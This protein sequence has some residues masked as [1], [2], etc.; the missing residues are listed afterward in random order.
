[1]L[2]VALLAASLY[3][4]D[5][6]ESEEMTETV[7]P[8]YDVALH[9]D[10]EENIIFSRYDVDV[11]LDDEKLGTIPHGDVADYSLEADEGEHRI[12]FASV[13]DSTTTGSVVIDVAEDCSL[14]YEIQCKHS[15]IKVE[16]VAETEPESE[17]ETASAAAGH[18]KETKEAESTKTEE[19]EE[20]PEASTEKE[21]PAEEKAPV[22]EEPEA[23]EEEPV[24]EPAPAEESA[25]EED[26][27]LTV[28]NCPELAAILAT[29]NEGDPA[30]AE[31]AE[32]HK[33]DTIEFDG[34]ITYW[35]NHGSYKTRFDFMLGAGEYD[36]DRQQGP[37]FKFDNVNRFDLNLP[38]DVDG[39]SIG[40]SVRVTAV[41]GSYSPDTFILL[42][43]PVSVT[44]R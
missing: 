25:P 33:G 27:V 23:V 16:E 24:E 22:E 19:P 30:I 36:P 18:S 31:F 9:V 39:L 21:E 41:V 28:D 4:C 26:A 11:Y 15:E 43:D 42:L 38:D 10:C 20:E 40:D 5:D 17:A 34:C 1:M 7:V 32:E 14:S 44:L 13:D 3:A 6:T 37:L 2:A 29:H 12:K 35:T 8:T